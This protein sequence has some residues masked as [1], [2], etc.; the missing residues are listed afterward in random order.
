ME[1]NPDLTLTFTNGVELI[2]GSFHPIFTR[3]TPSE[4]KLDLKAFLDNKFPVPTASAVIKAD[5]I[6]QVLDIIKQTKLQVFHFDYLIWCVCALK[7]NMLF[8]N[9]KAIVYRVHTSSLLRSTPNKIMYESG[10]KLDLFFA[11]LLGHE[12]EHYFLN[13]DWW[14]YLELSFIELEEG[15]WFSSLVYLYKSLWS[16]AIRKHNK[17]WIILKDYG[18]RVKK[19]LRHS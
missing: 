1:Q 5:V 18:Y 11:K 9:H 2:N 4:S 13:G 16:N 8:L 14:T 17:Q 6:K 15:N 3:H 19:K 12:H 10:L 7:G